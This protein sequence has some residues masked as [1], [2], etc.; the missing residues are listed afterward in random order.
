MFGSL[1]AKDTFCIFIWIF[2]IR[3]GIAVLHRAGIATS[4]PPK[5][6][7]APLGLAMIRMGGKQVVSGLSPAAIA[8]NSFL[9]CHLSH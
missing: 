2:E 7:L 6:V 9:A 5:D 1:G 3:C 4:A 8:I